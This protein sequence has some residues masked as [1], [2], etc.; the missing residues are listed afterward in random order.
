MLHVAPLSSMHTHRMEP[1]GK[2][3][4][5]RSYGAVLGKHHVH[6]NGNHSQTPVFTQL[7]SFRARYSKFRHLCNRQAA[8]KPPCSCRVTV[9]A[10]LL[11]AY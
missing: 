7:A 1:L 11:V 8:L 4:S 2:T 6:T 9:P 5:G 3:Q 10:Q